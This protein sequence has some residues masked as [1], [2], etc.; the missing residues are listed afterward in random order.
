MPAGTIDLKLE[1]YPHQPTRGVARRID[2]E[3]CCSF[4]TVGLDKEA[5]GVVTTTD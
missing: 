2:I 4:E 3:K 5:S 1:K